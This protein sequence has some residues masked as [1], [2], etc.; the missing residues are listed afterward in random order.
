M[1]VLI[2]DD[3]YFLQTSR[4]I[5]RNPVKAKPRSGRTKK[6]GSHFDLAMAI[7]LLQQSPQIPT[8]ELNQY[9]FLGELS[10]NGVLRPCSGVSTHG[11]CLKTRGY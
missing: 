11:H 5:H 1:S 3:A 2:E 8:K 4:Y 9:G 7:G 10:L 6:K